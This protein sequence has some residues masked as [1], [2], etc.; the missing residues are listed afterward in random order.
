[1]RHRTFRKFLFFN[2]IFSFLLLVSNCFPSI[3]PSA[4]EWGT[5]QNSVDHILPYSRKRAWHSGPLHYNAGTK[6]KA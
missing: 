5:A 4:V 6:G 2:R 1:M 3:L